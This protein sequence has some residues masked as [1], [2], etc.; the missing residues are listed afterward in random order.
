[1]LTS[2][3]KETTWDVNISICWLSNVIIFYLF[4]LLFMMCMCM[5]CYV[6]N[7]HGYTCVFHIYGGQKRT[8]CVIHDS[9]CD[10]VFPW[11]RSS[12][13]SEQ[14]PIFLL[15]SSI[16]VLRLQAQHSGFF[17]FS[18]SESLCCCFQVKMSSV[19]STWLGLCVWF[20]LQDCVFRRKSH[21]SYP[22]ASVKP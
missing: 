4:I 8:V 6:C 11:T 13:G 15:S 22:C 7:V 3:I 2:Q 5:W 21:C 20:S 19:L 16:R 12:G 18:L 9:S 17:L 10:R 1:M 14:A